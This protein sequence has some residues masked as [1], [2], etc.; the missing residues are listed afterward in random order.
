MIMTAAS[1]AC[2]YINTWQDSVLRTSAWLL[3]SAQCVL[4]TL[5]V[6]MSITTVVTTSH[7]SY[8]SGGCNIP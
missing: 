6:T 8:G 1:S 4:A 2:V 3:L 5:E 7:L